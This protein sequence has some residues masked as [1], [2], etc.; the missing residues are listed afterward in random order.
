MT[1][2]E[3]IRRYALPTELE[4]RL[5]CSSESGAECWGLWSGGNFR[6]RIE[7]PGT[8]LPGRLLWGLY[9]AAGQL[10]QRDVHP[11]VFPYHRLGV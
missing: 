6:G 5:I 10:L 7:R 9:D 11:R 2:P 1:I 4:P 8:P 3:A